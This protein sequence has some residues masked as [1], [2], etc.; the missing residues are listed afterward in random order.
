MKCDRGKTTYHTRRMRPLSELLLVFV[1][2][3]L[4]DQ[5]VR[6]QVLEAGMEGYISEPIRPEAPNT[7][8]EK[9]S[10]RS[11]AADATL[12]N[13][14]PEPLIPEAAFSV[15]MLL[16]RLENDRELLRELLEIFTDE[17]PRYREELR[18]AVTR[19][20]L[21][22]VSSTGHAMRGMFGSLGAERASALAAN[23]ERLGKGTET[24][25]LR[26][27]LEAFEAESATLLP[28]L[29]SYLAEDCK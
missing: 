19:L 7:E 5:K 12:A 21:Q 2:D 14:A 24:A 8:L 1:E 26:A 6:A 15:D 27:A 29:E 28:A 3:R 20:D 4:V 25:G 13:S 16:Q 18:S 9:A 11:E 10:E 17:F 22:R 23:L